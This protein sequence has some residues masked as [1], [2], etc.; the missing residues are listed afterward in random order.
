MCTL[1]DDHTSR[2]SVLGE[3][4]GELIGTGRRSGSKPSERQF[5]FGLG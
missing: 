3:F 1:L 2:P 5:D 4:D